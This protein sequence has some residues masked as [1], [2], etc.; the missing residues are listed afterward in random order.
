MFGLREIFT[1]VPDDLIGRPQLREDVNKTEY[2]SL[3]LVIGHAPVEQRVLKA[4]FLGEDR[5]L[6]ARQLKQAPAGVLDPLFPGRLCHGSRLSAESTAA[7][8]VDLEPVAPLDPQG[9]LAVQYLFR[10]VR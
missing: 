1:D 7:G 3:Q 5:F 10:A 9:N 2:A 4:V 6:P 8:R